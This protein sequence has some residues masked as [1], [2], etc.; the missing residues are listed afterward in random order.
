MRSTGCTPHPCAQGHLLPHRT[1]VQK[2]CGALYEAALDRSPFDVVAWHGNYAPYRYDLSRF[3]AFN[4]VTF[5]HL[6]PSSFTVLTAQTLEP[7]VAACD[8]VIFPPRWMVQEHSFRPPYYHRNCMSEYMGN[9]FGT[10]E[11]KQEG[12]APGGASLHSPMIGHGPDA[13]TF[14]Q[15]STQVWPP[16]GRQLRLGSP[17]FQPRR[18]FQP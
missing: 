18:P 5:D 6:D 16:G 15:G 2:F 9:I 14:E 4:S 11:A 17:Q 7:G 1:L 3:C 10:Y 13:H 12:F 8:F